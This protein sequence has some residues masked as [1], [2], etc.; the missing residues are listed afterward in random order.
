MTTTTTTP[1]QTCHH[2]TVTNHHHHHHLRRRHRRH[3]R[4]HDRRRVHC[5]CSLVPKRGGVVRCSA[6]EKARV[7][8]VLTQTLTSTAS[9]TGD[10]SVRG[11]EHAKHKSRRAKLS[12]MHCALCRRVKVYKRMT[13]VHQSAITFAAKAEDRQQNTHERQRTS[14][15]NCWLCC[16][17]FAANL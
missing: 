1:Q 9:I 7:V 13:F 16:W 15:E 6:S 8:R 17:F 11:A 5:E 3:R 4:R 10:S 12:C 14:D 2:R